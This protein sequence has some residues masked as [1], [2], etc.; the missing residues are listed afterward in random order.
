[1]VSPRYCASIECVPT[2]RVEIGNAAVPPEIVTGEPIAVLP[3]KNLTCPVA[4]V[5]VP[6]QDA[7]VRVAVNVTLWPNVE[8]F[9]SRPP[10]WSPNFESSETADRKICCIRCRR[11]TA[12]GGVVA[13]RTLGM[14][15][16]ATRSTAGL[17]G[18]VA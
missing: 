15:I 4:G 6:P 10:S 2:A 18:Q 12:R 11:Y 9:R 3:S 5:V 1:M 13:G 17:A 7:G 8:G 14:V 16:L